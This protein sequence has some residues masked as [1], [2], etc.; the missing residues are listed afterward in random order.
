MRMIL[1]KRKKPASA[2]VATSR[3]IRDD[4]PT[5]GRLGPNSGVSRTIRESW[6][7]WKYVLVCAFQLISV[8]HC[9]LHRT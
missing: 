7:V 3:E 6:Q 9:Y 2:V 4:I 1:K 8:K 5:I